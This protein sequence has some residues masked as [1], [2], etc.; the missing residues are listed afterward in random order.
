MTYIRNN[1]IHEDATPSLTHIE[2]MGFL[3]VTRI[4]A[5]KLSDLLREFM[6]GIQGQNT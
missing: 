3:D 5:L 2:I 4:F 6:N 1:I